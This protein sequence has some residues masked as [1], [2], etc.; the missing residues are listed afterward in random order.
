V[1]SSASVRTLHAI[2]AACGRCTDCQYVRAPPI[3]QLT[4]DPPGPCVRPHPVDPRAMPAAERRRPRPGRHLTDAPNGRRHHGQ[5]PAPRVSAHCAVLGRWRWQHRWQSVP[6]RGSIVLQQ[7]AQ[8][9]NGVGSAVGSPIL[10]ICL[11]LLVCIVV[12]FT[13]LVASFD[14]DLVWFFLSSYVLAAGLA[15]FV[16]CWTNAGSTSGLCTMANARLPAI[17]ATRRSVRS[18]IGS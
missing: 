12:C 8:T 16:L 9:S 7:W 10:T 17:C 18:A 1:R 11:S 2:D 15:S 6:C 14:G 13:G 3:G 5:R 4:R